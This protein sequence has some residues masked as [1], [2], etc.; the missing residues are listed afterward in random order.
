MSQRDVAQRSVVS[1]SNGYHIR[2]PSSGCKYIRE[3]SEPQSK[4]EQIGGV[5]TGRVDCMLLRAVF[6][7]KDVPLHKE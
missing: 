4:M 6:L 7:F 5:L 2:V 3:A 1:G